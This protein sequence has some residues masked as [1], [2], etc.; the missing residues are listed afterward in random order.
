MLARIA[1]L[2][3]LVSATPVDKFNP[4]K[5]YKLGE[6]KAMQQGL[7][8]YFVNTEKSK[9]RAQCMARQLNEQGIEN[10]RYDAVVMK[11]CP[12]FDFTCMND[13]VFTHHKDCFKSGADLIHMTQHGSGGKSMK[14]TAMAVLANWCSHKRLFH[15]IAKNTSSKY[16]VQ[17]LGRNFFREKILNAK[18]EEDTGTKTKNGEKVYIILEDDAILR[19]EF[20]EKINDFIANYDGSKW[21]MVQVDTFGGVDGRDKIGEYKNV[22]VYHPGMKGDYFGLHCILVKES[23][24]GKINLEMSLMPA[25]P[26]D[27]FPKLLKEVPDT[28]VLAWNPDIVVQPEMKT[29][30]KNVELPS[31]CDESIMYSTIGG[32]QV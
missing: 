21:D 27:W 1:L 32:A 30:G 20:A 25:V 19:P 24:M 10:E 7:K 8:A 29:K 23:S 22:S 17:T 11:E 14:N 2:A 16:D 31:Y 26:V 15:E 12:D 5:N 9:A 28:K 13:V 6:K 18:G 3:A 4:L